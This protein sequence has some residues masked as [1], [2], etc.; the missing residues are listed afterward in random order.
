MKNLIAALVGLFLIT[1]NYAQC[2]LDISNWDPLT[3]DI[4]IEA[5]N[6]E[7]CG[8]N[9]FTTEGNTCENSASPYVTNNETVSSIVLG[10]HVEGLDYNWL[11]CLD[12]KSVV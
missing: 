2:D 8:C 3:G 12:R 9:E 5:I 1:T 6:S 7:N 11:D 4:V 10:L